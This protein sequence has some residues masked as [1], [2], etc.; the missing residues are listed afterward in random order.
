MR[1]FKNVSKSIRKTFEGQF[2]TFK[3]VFDNYPTATN[4][5][6]QSSLK[7]IVNLAKQRLSNLEQGEI[8]DSSWENCR[9]NVLLSVL[10]TVADV[11]TLRVLDVGGG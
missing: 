9:I 5:H 6:S 11:G 3:D 8:P 1:K 10:S 7:G 2:S 4:Y